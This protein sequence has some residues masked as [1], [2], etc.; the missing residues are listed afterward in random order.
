MVDARESAALM[1]PQRV[2]LPIP[3]RMALRGLSDAAE[4]RADETV[5]DNPGVKRAR[6]PPGSPRGGAGGRSGLHRAA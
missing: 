6:P 3:V 5:V 4:C 1:A 2:I